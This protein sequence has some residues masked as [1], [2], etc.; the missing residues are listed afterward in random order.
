M[1]YLKRM[2]NCKHNKLSRLE[3]TALHGPNEYVCKECGEQ[4]L[5]LP[6]KQIIAVIPPREEK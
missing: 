3:E 6:R 4:F 2:D 5:V 1:V